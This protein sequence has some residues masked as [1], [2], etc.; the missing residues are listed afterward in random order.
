MFDAIDQEAAREGLAISKLKSVKNKRPDP[1][2]IIKKIK[3]EDDI[4][5]LR[6]LNILNGSRA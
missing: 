4:D 1:R 6:I 3:P 5:I 2:H